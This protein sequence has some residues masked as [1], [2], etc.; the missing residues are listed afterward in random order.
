[1]KR[2]FSRENIHFF[3]VIF[4]IY[5]SKTN[6]KYKEIDLKLAT[7]NED[8]NLPLYIET[9]DECSEWVP[10][11]FNPILIIKMRIKT[12][13]VYIDK[14]LDIPFKE[15]PA[16]IKTDIDKE[17]LAWKLYSGKVSIFD[18]IF[19]EKTPCRWPNYCLF[20]LGYF[21]LYSKNFTSDVTNFNSIK[22]LIDSGQIEKNIFSFGKWDLNQSEFVTSKLYI[23]NSHEN[24]FEDNVGTCEIQN[25]T[26]YF[27]C[28][29]N[30]FIFLNK[31]YSLINE[32][33]NQSYII[34]LSSEL[35][36]IYFPKYFED[37]FENCTKNDNQQFFCEELK[38]KLYLPLE[39]RNDNMNITLEVDNYERFYKYSF[40][41]LIS[42]GFSNIDFHEFDYIIFPLIMF[43]MFH[44][45]FDIENNTISFYTNDTSILEVSK[46]EEP[47][48]TQNPQPTQD[49]S[50]RKDDDP[51]GP[52][53]GLIVFLVILGILLIG[54][55]GYGGFLLYKKKHRPDIEKKFNK[56]SKFEDEDINENK[57]VY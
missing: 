33:N 32:K 5:I 13:G 21:D 39:L 43:K 29:F 26:G 45:Q 25:E 19:I 12:D 31:T 2:F 44:V 34:Y 23:G 38:D 48:P 57:L 15:N 41:Y 52:S 7:K 9:D 17:D 51:D 6:E 4:M 55:L 36:K 42:E 50:P 8:I 18:P 49:P 22:N 10:A 37:K 20:G 28:I 14:N 3:I 16:S 30:D 54:G 35:N 11:L 27:G 47:T 40:P 56:Y 1:M 24:F 46:K 53:A